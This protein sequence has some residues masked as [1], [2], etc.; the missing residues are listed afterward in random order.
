MKKSHIVFQR[1]MMRNEVLLCVFKV[2][3]SRIFN[4]GW[5]CQPVMWFFFKLLQCSEVLRYGD[6][7]IGHLLPCYI[8]LFVY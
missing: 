5:L 7:I 6:V 4:K 1:S 3:T 8:I 2:P